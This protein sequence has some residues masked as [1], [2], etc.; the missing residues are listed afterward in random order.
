MN[1]EFW[2]DIVID[3]GVDALKIFPFLLITYIF[4]EY[5]EHHT[6]EKMVRGLKNAGLFGPLIGALCGLAPQCGFS[7]AASNLYAARVISK[8]A[9]IA[10]FLSTSDEMLPLM[11]S[12]GVPAGAIGKILLL[13]VLIALGA[14]ILIDLFVEICRAPVETEAP[15]KKAA[16]GRGEGRKRGTR[17]E[18]HREHAH[19]HSHGHDHDHDDLDIHIHEICEREHCDCEKDG[20]FVSALKHSLKILLFIL[21]IS[22]AMNVFM[23]YIG[24]EG[25][26]Y[27]TIGNSYGVIFLAALFGLIPN[28]GV[29]VALTQLYTGGMIGAGALLSGL[30][31]GAGVGLLVLLRVN[32]PFKD[33]LKVITVL[34][35]FGVLSGCLI[36]ALGFSFI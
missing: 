24:S 29:S 8:G 33:S 34:W 10:V 16:K 19:S 21:V 26:Q 20:I 9:L 15:V 6:G 7:A 5:L 12:S 32:K 22:F 2:K 13:K 28:C 27:V 35:V 17:E 4:M 18:S 3:T 23:G 14:G 11:L 31:V 30:L 25:I 36:K 1:L